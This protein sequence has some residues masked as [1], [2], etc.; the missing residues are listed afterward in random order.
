M[1]QVVED[2]QRPPPGVVRLVAVTGGQLHVAEAD[3]GGRLEVAV[4]EG[5]EQLAGL[6]VAVPRLG[7]VAEALVG[8]A[9]AVPGVRLPVAVCRA[10]AAASGP[11]GRT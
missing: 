11:P 10:A 1:V 6:L 9:Q 4:A 8:V 2:D 3:Q 5:A 7:V